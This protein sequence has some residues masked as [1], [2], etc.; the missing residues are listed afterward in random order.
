VR[1]CRQ[2]LPCRS[3]SVEALLVG[4]PFGRPLDVFV[5]VVVLDLV[6]D[7]LDIDIDMVLFLDAAPRVA[8]VGGSSSSG[9]TS[10]GSTSPDTDV[11]TESG[12]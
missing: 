7:V 4:E 12:R 6:I 11:R 9:S 1:S 2:P 8:P 10:S 5:A 3:T